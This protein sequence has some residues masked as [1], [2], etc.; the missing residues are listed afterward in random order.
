MRP[1]PAVLS[2]LGTA[3]VAAAA[4]SDEG[5]ITA[6]IEFSETPASVPGTVR[7]GLRFAV[8]PEGTGRLEI[9]VLAPDETRLGQ[10]LLDLR[11][12]PGESLLEPNGGRWRIDGIPAGS[13]RS[14][15]ARAFPEGTTSS[16]PEPSFTGRLDGLRVEP[17]QVTQAGVL[18][19]SPSGV[20]DPR[21]DQD[22]PALPSLSLESDPRGEQVIVR[23]APGSEADL[24]G[25][26][27][28]VDAMLT[29]ATPIL[30]RG[31]AFM[32]GDPIA[33]NVIVAARA[34]R[35]EPTSVILDA[36]ESVPVRVLLYAYDADA[37]GD[38]LNWSAAAAATTTALDTTPPGS[39]SAF[40]AR[41]GI[42]LTL[43]FVAPGED[44][45]EGQISALELRG[46]PSPDQLTSDFETAPPLPPPV[47][48]PPAPGSMVQTQLSVDPAL[49]PAWVGLRARDRA[50]NL[51]PVAVAEVQRSAPLPLRVDRVSPAIAIATADL[52]LIGSGFGGSPGRLEWVET[53]TTRALP[54]R[55]WTDSL[56][57]TEVPEGARSGQLRLLRPDGSSTQVALAVI[58][59]RSLPVASLDPFE[60]ISGPSTPAGVQVSALHRE[61]GRFGSPTH[62][63]EHL[64]DG[65]PLGTPYVPLIEPRSSAVAGD[66]RADTN[67]FAFVS[68]GGPDRL[69]TSV[70]SGSTV[71]PNATRLPEG[72]SAGD[73]DGLGLI[74]LGGGSADRPP[75]FLAFTEAGLLRAAR[76]A[77]LRLEPFD[78]FIQVLSSGPFRALTGVRGPDGGRLSVLEGSASPAERSL[79]IIPLDG[80]PAGLVRWGSL[81]PSEAGAAV[82]PAP[83]ST[84]YLVAHERPETTGEVHIAFGLARTPGPLPHRLRSAGGT[85]RLED[86]GFVLGPSGPRAVLLWSALAS[87]QAELRWTEVEVSDLTSAAVTVRTVALDIAPEDLRGRLGCKRA[88]SP[89]CLAVWGS[90]ESTPLLFE[91]R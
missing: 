46:G 49:V 67:L 61:E 18:V 40:T 28:A 50:G 33:P 78:D 53:S 14:L 24:A 87:G 32:P 31:E 63:I 75:A 17:G 60:L 39:P 57:V 76:V 29:G 4:C 48:V 90:R 64:V 58:A 81:G 91:R 34:A 79:W 68:G 21:F 8:L 66:Y 13:D 16:L 20:R 22:A 30:A 82:R 2:L 71:A 1:A 38:P 86:V 47:D 42:G 59:R 41:L 15:V 45:A 27:V 26:L 51:G 9:E 62:A 80:D 52:E 85:A 74:L 83:S 36:A 70:V 25:Y 69:T 5:G 88:P 55:R 54:V 7:R 35:G 89:G 3:A 73:V 10:A 77:D 12:G 37:S 19:L 43:S 84:D 44:G 72:V 56:V 11:P 65:T 6:R 23:W